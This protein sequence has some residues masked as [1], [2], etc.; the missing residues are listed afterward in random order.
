MKILLAVDE[1]WCSENAVTEVG[2]RSW[3]SDTTVRVLHVLEKF[4]PPAADLWYDA[5][6]SLDLAKRELSERYEEIIK[7]IADR[8]RQDGLRVE[9]V[10]REGHPSK[11]I[12]EEA[13]EWGAD[14]IVI[15]SHGYSGLKRLVLGSTAQK[16]LDRAPCPVEVVQEKQKPD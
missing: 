10:L 7:Q 12:V 6:G 16:V 2:R 13:D 4:V 5:G 11:V 9:T 14:L 8:L 15:G 1:S 3:D